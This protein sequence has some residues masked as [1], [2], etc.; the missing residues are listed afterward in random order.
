M[1][2]RLP[3]WVEKGGFVLA[4]AAGSVNAIAIMGFNHQGVSH[5]SGIST[6]LGIEAVGANYS[7]A[8]LLGLVLA[9]F[10]IGAAI[11]GFVI[12][13]QSLTLSARYSVALF[14]E[15]TLLLIAMWLLMRQSTIGLLLASAACG[16]QNAMTSTYSAAVVRTTHVTGLFTD[17]GVSLGLRLR[18]EPWDR[19]RVWLS[20]ALISGFLLGGVAGAW[21]F[22]LARFFALI[23]PAVLTA[24][25][26][27][28]AFS[29]AARES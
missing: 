1:L 19:R 24:I 3:S 26:G 2:T 6:L 28:A 7:S 18:G 8:I 15:S 29:L 21:G 10:L 22:T 16:L 27:L 9:A 25:L 14:G 11:S 12:G 23:F 4:L 5:L 13:G 17:L 20:A